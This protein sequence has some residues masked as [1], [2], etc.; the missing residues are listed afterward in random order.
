[1]KTSRCKYIIIIF[2]I[3]FQSVSCSFPTVRGMFKNPKQSISCSPTYS[4]TPGTQTSLDYGRTFGSCSGFTCQSGYS[5]SGSICIVNIIY[6]A[7]GPVNS[8]YNGTQSSTDGGATWSAC[9]GFSCISYYKVSGSSCVHMITD[10]RAEYW[11]NCPS[12][13]F[14]FNY[15]YSSTSTIC[16]MT[17]IYGVWCLDTFS[18]GN[19]AMIS[20]LNNGWR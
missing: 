14:Y 13:P 12:T 10:W 2:S 15:A 7:C 9:V 20:C 19:D 16:P 4:A 5:I 3:L 8:N 1:M 17:N 6:Q 18:Y 11:P